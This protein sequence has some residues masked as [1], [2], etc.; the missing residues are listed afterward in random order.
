MIFILLSF[1]LY[2][3]RV[4]FNLFHQGDNE[5]NTRAF[6][7]HFLATSVTL[8]LALSACGGKASGDASGGGAKADALMA[9]AG[10]ALPDKPSALSSVLGTG[11]MGLCT[12]I[13]DAKNKI[14]EANAL[15]KANGDTAKTDQTGK[16]VSYLSDAYNDCTARLTAFRPET[17]QK[18]SDIGAGA[19]ALVGR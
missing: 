3:Q 7:R 8:C 2:T 12:S 17:V 9:E 4:R 16:M 6:S 19:D 14:M 5:M 15:Y 1:P 13:D 18:L 11:N 10:K